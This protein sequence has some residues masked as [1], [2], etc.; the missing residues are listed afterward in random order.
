MPVSPKPCDFPPDSTITNHMAWGMA[1]ANGAR[2]RDKLALHLGEIARYAGGL[3][4][5]AVEQGFNV[6]RKPDGSSYTDA[7]VAAEQFILKAL[8]TH[9]PDVPVIAEE[10]MAAIME[11]GENT[12]QSLQKSTFFLVDPL[13]G[14][15]DFCKGGLEVLGQ[16][17]RNRRWHSHSRSSLRSS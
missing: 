5:E 10:Q 6:Y 11:L 3:I 4:L 15:R 16:H 12:S 1:D 17:R 9:F 14:T 13:D 7:D 2:I 8:N